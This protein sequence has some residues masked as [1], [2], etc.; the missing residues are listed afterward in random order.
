MEEGIRLIRKHAVKMTSPI[1]GLE[2][3][4]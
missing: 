1:D 3:G 4:R 2:Y